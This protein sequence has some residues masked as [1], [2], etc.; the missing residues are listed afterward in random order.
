MLKNWDDLTADEKKLFARQMEV[1]AAYLAYTDHEIGR[2]IQAVDDLG[3]LDNT[4][5]IYISGDN[6][7][8]AEGTPH[9]TPSEMTTFNG[10]D[11]PV[12]EQLKLMDVWGSDQTYPHMAVGWTWCMDTPFKWTKQI[13]SHFGGTRQG[14]AI[15]WPNRI[16]DAGGIRH[17]FHHVIDIVPTILEATGVTAPLQVDGIA[18]H[19]IEGV[20]MAY[21]FDK[22]NAKAPSQRKTQYF[23]MFGMRA[24]YHEGWIASTTPYRAPWEITLPSPKDIVNGI[25]WEL[26]HVDE[27]WTQ[28]H[29]V[30]KDNPA[31]LQELQD[32]FW[33]EATKYQVLP[34]DASGFTRY[35]IER[36]SST[37]GRMEFTYTNPVTGILP[38]NEPN[39]LNKSYVITADVTVP[40]SGGN[41]VLVTDGG[42]FG[43]YGLYLLEGKPVFTYNLLNLAA[44]VGRGPKNFRRASTKSLSTLNTPGQ[45]SA[46][47]ALAC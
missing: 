32:L 24:L 8:S 31:K 20:S 21:A 11:V 16:K 40:E 7:S 12:A 13:A 44:T 37:A 25:K 23:E 27:D 14:V 28:F 47:A 10:I 35:L 19:P 38:G 1:Y 30:A 15:S 33:V 29:D 5:I 4:L 3:K 46:K 42:R 2:V 41:G 18:Q 36:P 43:G 17:Q 26:Y 6:G 45:E 22:A 34:L 39:V 9:G